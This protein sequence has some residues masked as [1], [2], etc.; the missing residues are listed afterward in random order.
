MK[1]GCVSVLPPE[2]QERMARQLKRHEGFCFSAYL[3]SEGVLTIGYGHNCKA[4]PVNGVAKP[5]DI[6]SEGQA[7]MLFK[8]DLDLAEAQIGYALPWI[9]LLKYPRR[10]VLI[11]MVFNMGL[12]SVASGRG[13]MGFRRMLAA[14]QREDYAAAA[15]EMLNS[16]WARQ[17]GQRARELAE[18]MESGQWPK[19]LGAAKGGQPVETLHWAKRQQGAGDEQPFA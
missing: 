15:H 13:L 14:M 12:G 10:A 8:N 16:H 17:V 6:I 4:W 11:N 2:E 3:D 7:E 1:K 18:Q 5:G 9:D 19:Y